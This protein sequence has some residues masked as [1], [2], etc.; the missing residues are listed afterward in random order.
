MVVFM[1]ATTL[2]PARG[3][4][5]RGMKALFFGLMLEVMV[6]PVKVIRSIIWGGSY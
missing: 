5:L 3:S 2:L 1:M 6:N 4:F